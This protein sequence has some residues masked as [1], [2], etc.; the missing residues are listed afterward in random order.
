MQRKATRSSVLQTRDRS[1]HSSDRASTI[2]G[3]RGL[4]PG[5]R[6]HFSLSDRRYQ[7]QREHTT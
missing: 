1:N 3:D 7:A 6:S 2:A 5:K 4:E